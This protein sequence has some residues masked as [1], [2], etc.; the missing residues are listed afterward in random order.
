MSA[1]DTVICYFYFVSDATFMLGVLL[2]QALWVR[3]HD[4][5]RAKEEEESDHVA[6]SLPPLADAFRGVATR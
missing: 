3:R 1:K 4:I 6:S 2:L 5:L